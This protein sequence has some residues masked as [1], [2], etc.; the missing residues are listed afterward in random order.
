MKP[1]R[2]CNQQHKK[3]APAEQIWFLP[4]RYLQVTLNLPPSYCL[5]VLKVK[6]LTEVYMAPTY[7]V[8]SQASKCILFQS[9]Y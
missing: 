7:K 6:V 2:G 1:T 4:L 3:V 5:H 8:V 9:K